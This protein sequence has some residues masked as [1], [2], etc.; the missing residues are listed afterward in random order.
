MIQ[1]PPNQSGEIMSTKNTKIETIVLDDG[2][3]AERH[4]SLDENGNE[5]VEIFAEEKRPLKL[6][7]RIV[8]EMKN[9]VA[10]EIHETIRDGEVAFQE[11]HSLEPEV[12]LQLRSKIGV[13]DHAKLIDGD[14]VSKQ[15]IHS[16]IT[17]GVVAGVS[18][19]MDN[20]EPVTA[21]SH[22]PKKFLSAQEIVEQNVEEKNNKLATW[23]NIGLAA[24][25]VGQ[26]IAYWIFL[27]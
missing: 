9:I 15:D 13:V 12:P 18:A 2:R 6:E 4:V 5:V 22:S 10:K 24:A 7:K 16:M 14:Y 19:L 23:T 3:R 20:F 21:Q 8:R 25:I 27:S 1:N 26:L 17:E 11:V